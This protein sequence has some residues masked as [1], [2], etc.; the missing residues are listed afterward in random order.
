MRHV[1]FSFLGFFLVFF[2]YF[3]S[4]LQFIFVLKYLLK[5][6]LFMR[7]LDK[8]KKSVNIILQIYEN[9]FIKYDEIQAL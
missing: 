9:F 6:Y 1:A 8:F 4:Y 2:T 5:R 7:R 3:T